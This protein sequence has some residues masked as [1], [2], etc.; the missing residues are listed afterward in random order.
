MHCAPY[1][2]YVP[3]HALCEEGL[4]RQ[5]GDGTLIRSH[6]RREASSR[7]GTADTLVVNRGFSSSVG[8]H[9]ISFVRASGKSFKTFVFDALGVLEGME[10]GCLLGEP[11]RRRRFLPGPALP[12]RLAVR[13]RTP[14]HPWYVRVLDATGMISLVHA[15]VDCFGVRRRKV[16]GCLLGAPVSRHPL[17]P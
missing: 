5:N 2:S 1:A 9:R 11:T 13:Q 14:T 15:F 12:R 8:L 10:D 3:G 16:D 7:G 6:D 17:P 4:Q